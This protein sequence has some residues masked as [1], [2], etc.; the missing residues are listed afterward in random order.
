[1]ECRTR[2]WV[3]EPSNGNKFLYL[4]LRGIFIRKHN[5]LLFKPMN[6]SLSYTLAE[7]CPTPAR[8]VLTT[9]EGNCWDCL[10]VKRFQSCFHLIFAGASITACPLDEN[11]GI[12][13]YVEIF[14]AGWKEKT[15]YEHGNPSKVI[16]VEFLR[17]ENGEYSFTWMEMIPRPPLGLVGKY[18]HKSKF[19]LC[20]TC[21]L[22]SN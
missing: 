14:S 15:D 12:Y 3:I 4:R 11:S 13:E 6:T 21:Q 10:N 1:M 18:F 16:S 19:Q 22:T 7:K 2:P 20:S 8:V 5:P 17:P 9:G